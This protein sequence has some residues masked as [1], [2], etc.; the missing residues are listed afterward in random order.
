MNSSIPSKKIVLVVLKLP[1]KKILGSRGF[2]DEY[3]ETF[4][5][6]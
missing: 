3:Y 6:K 1:T 5:R 4:K 2:T